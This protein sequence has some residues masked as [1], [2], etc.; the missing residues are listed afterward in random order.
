MADIF[1]GSAHDLTVGHLTQ[2]HGI[3]CHQT[4][5]ALDQ[6]NGQLAFAD[7]AVAK[8]QDAFAVHLHQ[9]AVPGD[10]GRKL[11]IQY[12]DQ[13][14]H[15][16]AGSLVGTQQG[17]RV[18]LRQFLH[19]REGRQFLAAADDDRRG[20]LPEQLLQRLVAL[21]CR[22]TGQKVHLCQTHDLQ[23]ELIEIIII[24]RQKQTRAV[25]LSDLHADFIQRPG[26]VYH[27]H[28]DAVGQRFKRNIE[29]THPGSSCILLPRCA[30]GIL[31]HIIIKFG[32][33][34]NARGAVFVPTA[35]NRR[36]IAACAQDFYIFL[37][38]HGFYISAISDFTLFF[39]T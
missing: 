38:L 16:S 36:C 8:D 10:A 34:Y 21:F 37:T 23:A 9:H 20:L 17:N 29:R 33:K 22:Q 32:G 30:A 26:G 25:D 31:I 7:A 28:A 2:F 15:Q 27:F 12:A 39:Y 18:L 13:A 1:R 3:I 6:L 11:Q 24:A 5:A 35:G 4:V 14:A 19:L